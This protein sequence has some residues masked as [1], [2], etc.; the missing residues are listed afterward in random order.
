MKKGYLLWR[1]AVTL[2]KLTCF[3]GPRWTPLV[4]SALVFLRVAFNSFSFKPRRS[5]VV[6][7]LN[8]TQGSFSFCFSERLCVADLLS[9]NLLLLL[10]ADTKLAGSS[11]A[12]PSSPRTITTN[13]S[14]IAAFSVLILDNAVCCWYWCCSGPTLYVGDTTVAI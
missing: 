1:S 14:A 3:E 9:T 13:M 6:S 11:F 7:Y 4:L 8:Y 5:C 12:I 2:E 10:L